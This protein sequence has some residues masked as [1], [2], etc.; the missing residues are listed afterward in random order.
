MNKHSLVAIWHWLL[1]FT[2]TSYV[3][4]YYRGL[5]L[6]DPKGQVHCCYPLLCIFIADLLEAGQICCVRNSWNSRHPCITCMVP[7]EQLANVRS[8]YPL[9][10]EVDMMHVFQTAKDCGNSTEAE[11]MCKEMSIHFQEVITCL[12]A[13]F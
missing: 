2:L 6:L 10:K 7:K 4:I 8:V 5:Q 1:S 12:L 3:Y 11:N 13:W 9:R